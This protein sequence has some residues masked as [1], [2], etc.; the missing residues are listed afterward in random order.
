MDHEKEVRWLG[1]SYRDL[2]AFPDEPRREAGFQLSKI[3]AGLDPDDWKPFHAAGPGTR[4]IRIRESPGIFRVIYVAKFVEA[5]YVLH[6]FQKKTQTTS[7][8]D[9]DIAEARYRAIINHF[10][11]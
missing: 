11:G 2:L 5:V 8:Q 9:K 7:K 1:S 4:E 3:Q 6:C 10:K